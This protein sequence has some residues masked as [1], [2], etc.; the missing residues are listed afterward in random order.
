MKR[1]IYL[2]SGVLAFVIS[3][4]L[5]S[6]P[7]NRW[8]TANFVRSDDDSNFLVSVL[9]LGIWPVFALIGGLLGHLLY[10]RSHVSKLKFNNHDKK[11]TQP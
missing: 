3:G 9:F 4:T 5:L 7:F 1:L 2:I 10:R 11:G 6:I 8:Y